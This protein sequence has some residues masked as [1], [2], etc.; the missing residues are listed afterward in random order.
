MTGL[1][2]ESTNIICYKEILALMPIIQNT[3]V[4]LRMYLEFS[5]LRI[6]YESEEKKLPFCVIVLCD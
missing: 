3:V 5:V 6:N 1:M 2:A 4:S